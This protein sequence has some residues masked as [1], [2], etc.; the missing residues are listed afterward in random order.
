MVAYPSWGPAVSAPIKSDDSAL[1]RVTKLL[2]ADITAAFLSAKQALAAFYSDPYE[3]A[4][5]IVL[6]VVAIFVLSI[7]Y[8]RFYSHI[9]NVL[10]IAFLCLSFIV[11]AIALANTDFMNFF[12]GLASPIKAT[13]IVLPILWAFLISPIFS[14]V[15]GNRVES[16]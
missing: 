6:T 7:F 3:R 1:D 15:L 10:H 12:P 13:S 5:P 11:F 14:G 9:T 8:F 2:P 4:E 16:E